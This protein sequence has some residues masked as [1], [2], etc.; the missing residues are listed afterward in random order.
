MYERDKAVLHDDGK[1]H[2]IVL[3]IKKAIKIDKYFFIYFFL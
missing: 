2:H 3:S 1:I